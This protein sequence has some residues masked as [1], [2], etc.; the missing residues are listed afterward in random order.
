MKAVAEDAGVALL[1]VYRH[2]PSMALLE[3]AAGELIESSL[4]AGVEPF[5]PSDRVAQR[6]ALRRFLVNYAELPEGHR[7]ARATAYARDSRKRR[8]GARMAHV[9]ASYADAL[10][11]RR[12]AAREYLRDV[13]L[14]IGSTGVVELF[15]EYLELSGDEV[16][17]RVLWLID[18]LTKA[19]GG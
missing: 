1:T 6:R 3:Q 17:D 9:E 2:F 18:E 12:G 15:Q 13:L 10:G 19:R 7:R 14:V 4:M 11:R 8:L 16:A 5:E